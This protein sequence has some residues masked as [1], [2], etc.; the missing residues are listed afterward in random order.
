MRQNHGDIMPDCDKIM[1]PEKMKPVLALAKNE[2]VAAAIA[3]TAS[4]DGLIFLDRKMKPKRAARA[5]KILA[6]KAGVQVSPSSVRFGRAGVDTGYDATTVRFSINRDAPGTM[7]AKLVE[8]V[9][10]VSYRNVELSI[11]L[12]L[13][14]E[15][16][17]GDAPQSELAK[18][19][20]ENLRAKLAE[21][22]TRIIAVTDSGTAGNLTRR[23]IAAAT[24]LKADQLENVDRAIADIEDALQAAPRLAPFPLRLAAISKDIATVGNDEIKNGLLV[25]ADQVTELSEA[26]ITPDG[27]AM[28]QVKQIDDLVEVLRNL[29]GRATENVAVD[30]LADARNQLRSIAQRISRVG[31]KK[32]K[33]ALLA[34]ASQ[35]NELVKAGIPSRSGAGAQV[36]AINDSI[37]TL[38][39][40]VDGAIQRYPALAEIHTKVAQTIAAIAKSDDAT[41]RQM[42]DK[43]VKQ[44]GD[45][46]PRDLASEPADQTAIRMA[47]LTSVAVEVSDEN[48]GTQWKLPKPQMDA[49]TKLYGVIGLDP[50]FEEADAPKRNAVLEELRSNTFATRMRSEWKATPSQVSEADLRRLQA[51]VVG[52]LAPGLIDDPDDQLTLVG[53]KELGTTSG[54]S[55]RKKVLVNATTLTTFDNTANTIVHETTHVYQKHLAEQLD[56]EAIE[57]GNPLYLQVQMFKLNVRG[58]LQAP[59][60]PGPAAPDAELLEY[61][62][63]RQAYENQPVEKHAHQAGNEA[64][65]IFAVPATLSKFANVAADVGRFLGG[66]ADELARILNV[67]RQGTAQ[68]QG[69]IMTDLEKLAKEA[70]DAANASVS[71]K[72][73]TVNLSLFLDTKHTPGTFDRLDARRSACVKASETSPVEALAGLAA[74]NDEVDQHLREQSHDQQQDV[75]SAL[76]MEQEIRRIFDEIK[77]MLSIKGIGQYFDTRFEKPGAWDRFKARWNTAW[78]ASE[79]N[80][81]QSLA[82]LRDVSDQ[83]SP[84]CPGF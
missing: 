60:D 22:K 46:D 53:S 49:M 13:E 76:I 15:P 43:M 5:L 80:P 66:R 68:A 54:L 83:N 51:A 74:L 52:K 44:I 70:A 69:A 78:Q 82:E 21:L 26:G 64:E 4:G 1:T 56:L 12:A 14:D 40:Q 3:L 10:Q 25:K 20:R 77:D 84:T 37:K 39:R 8:V 45:I 23:F 31:D 2:P 61:A 9:K 62:R 79:A 30:T 36:S 27:N 57:P 18:P 33:Q 35:V 16:D 38:G 65:R 7:R 28:A 73:A 47:V 48:N 59:P 63:L 34:K 41:R 6:D 29:V 19:T 75:K 17:E 42:A 24:S 71:T 50:S 11:D 32:I 58:Y 81:E 72:L 55:I 67:L